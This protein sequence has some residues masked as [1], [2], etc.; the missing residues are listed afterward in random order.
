MKPT[1][2]AKLKVNN[3]SQNLIDKMTLKNILQLQNSQ[4]EFGFL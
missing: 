4:D 3:G 1:R 2:V